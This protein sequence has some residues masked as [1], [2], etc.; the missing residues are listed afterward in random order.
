MIHQLEILNLLLVVLLSNGDEIRIMDES[1]VF[2]CTMD[3]DKTEHVNPQSHHYSSGR[4]PVTV[5]GPE[6]FTVNVGN[7]GQI[8][9]YTNKCSI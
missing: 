4:L 8:N 3:N 7:S 5:D 2:T 1:V 6:Q 9:K